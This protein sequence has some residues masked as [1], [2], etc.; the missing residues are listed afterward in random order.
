MVYSWLN[1]FHKINEKEEEENKV[2]Q[3]NLADVAAFNSLSWNRL[4]FRKIK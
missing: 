4:M 3:L 1:S 2:N